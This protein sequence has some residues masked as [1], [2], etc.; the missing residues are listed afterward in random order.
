QAIAGISDDDDSEVTEEQDDAYNEAIK[1]V[2]SQIT[3]ISPGENGV[4][5][6]TQR[7]LHS[8]SICSFQNHLVRLFDGPFFTVFP[9]QD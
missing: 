6:I 1:G 9:F 7:I 5:R 8:T 2:E 4:G 3:A